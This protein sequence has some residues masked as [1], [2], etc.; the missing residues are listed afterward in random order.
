MAGLPIPSFMT[1]LDQSSVWTGREE[2]VRDHAICEFR[3]EKTTIHQKT[4]VDDRYK[5]TVYYNQT[6]GE[7]FDLQE[8]PGEIRNL[9]DDADFKELKAK[10]LLSY[11]WA[12]LGKEP[13]AMPRIWHA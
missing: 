4:Y 8:D 12:E 11:I 10:L 1:G 5:L 6:Y 9:W 3:H 13:L 7:L 2:R